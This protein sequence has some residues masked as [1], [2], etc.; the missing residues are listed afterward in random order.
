MKA[1]LSNIVD[2]GVKD[3]TKEKVIDD[4]DARTLHFERFQQGKAF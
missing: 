3:V 2:F 4:F 1:A